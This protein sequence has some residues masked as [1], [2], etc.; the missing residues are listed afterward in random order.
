[1]RTSR[2]DDDRITITDEFI[3][4]DGHMIPRNRRMKCAR[5]ELWLTV[6]QTLARQFCPHCH[7]V[8]VLDIP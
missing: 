3:E 1:M 7:E 8:V 2:T 5:C 6:D 4:R